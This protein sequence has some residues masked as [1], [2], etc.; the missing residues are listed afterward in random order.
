M[1]SHLFRFFL[2][3]W[4]R[5]TRLTPQQLAHRLGQAASPL[6]L[7]VRTAEE[8]SSG[9]I[10]G[11]TLLPVDELE[12]KLTALAPYRERLIVTV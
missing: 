6:V 2:A 7:D 8:F 11:A 5:P 10:A 9:H 3:L 4:R 1:R 12:Q